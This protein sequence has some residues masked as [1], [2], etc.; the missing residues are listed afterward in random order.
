VRLLELS[1]SRE[2]TFTLELHPSITLVSGLGPDGRRWLAEVLAAA[3]RG[4]HDGITGTVEVDG[5]RTELTPD[6]VAGL[7]VESV[8]LIVRAADLPRPEAPEAP[9]PAAELDQAR[10]ALREAEE[11]RDRAEAAVARARE[12]RP[13]SDDDALGRAEADL[14]VAR[15]RRAR[16]VARV[17]A[18]VAARPDPDDAVAARA[19]AGSAARRSALE[20]RRQEVLEGL[21]ELRGVDPA[22]VAT[23]RAGAR[24]PQALAAAEA[25][26]DQARRELTE[27]EVKL[28]PQQADSETVAALEAAHEAVLEAEERAERRL[29]GRRRP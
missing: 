5:T 13:A 14:A 27:A 2:P 24:S 12:M 19:R 25:A 17:E 11:E 18:A 23:A 9:A 29:A 15:D 8:D 3:L 6:I 4:G 1:S 16:A 21:A 28:N 10:V 7:G 20:V 26:V 22:A